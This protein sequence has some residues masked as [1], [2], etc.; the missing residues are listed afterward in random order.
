MVAVITAASGSC[1]RESSGSPMT[2]PLF[3]GHHRGLWQLLA[4]EASASPAGPWSAWVTAVRTLR[5][6]ALPRGK[7]GGMKLTVVIREVSSSW[8]RMSSSSRRSE[9]MSV[10]TWREMMSTSVKKLPTTS[11]GELWSIRASTTPALSGHSPVVRAG[12]ARTHVAESGQTVKVV[13]AGLDINIDV[14]AAAHDGLD[15]I[16]D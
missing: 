15:P 8:L 4:R 6:G 3:E 5:I 13:F 1:L 14:R 11:A 7:S 12:G 9:E 16:V 10:L 2:D